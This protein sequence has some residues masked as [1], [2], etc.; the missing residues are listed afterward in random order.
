VP[1]FVA[2]LPRR[3]W[4]TINL[5]VA[6]VRLHQA[7]QIDLPV[8]VDA[9]PKL[10]TVWLAVNDL[11]GNVSLAAFRKDLHSLL[12]GLRQA[13]RAEVLVGNLPDLA[14]DPGVAARLGPDP[15]L[16]LRSWNTVILA[17]ARDS[18]T[19]LVDLFSHW[20]E[21]A[22]HPEYVGSDGLHPSAAGYQRIAD[23]FRAAV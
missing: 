7:L 17:E 9:H 10:V 4:K 23:I 1:R 6:G 14:L 12:H 21:L 18:G 11:L 16:N 2:A 20:R 5:G 13:T 19:R 22:Q 3:R 8:A 15:A